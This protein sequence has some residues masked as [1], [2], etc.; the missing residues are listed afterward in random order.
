MASSTKGH[1]R[2]LERRRSVLQLEGQLS[3]WARGSVPVL[4][5]PPRLLPRAEP[6]E[7]ESDV[8][9]TL[10]CCQPQGRRAAACRWPQQSQGAMPPRG[11][12]LTAAR[13]SH[14]REGGNRQAQALLYDGETGAAP[15]PSDTSAAA[16]A[17]DSGRG[18]R[19]PALCSPTLRR[20]SPPTLV[21]GARGGTPRFSPLQ[22]PSS[23]RPG[24]LE[25]SYR[26]ARFL[27]AA[28]SCP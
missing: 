10:P 17:A 27:R 5:P 19:C 26:A 28:G 7:E 14:R 25:G 15:L 23:R 4:T 8:R 1:A 20:F 22:V 11:W 2:C 13:N 9:R 24:L 18:S 6:D 21:S 16:D 12:A 3:R